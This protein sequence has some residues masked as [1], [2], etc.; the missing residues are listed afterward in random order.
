MTLTPTRRSRVEA[1][2]LVLALSGAALAGCLPSGTS[3]TGSATPSASEAPTTAEPTT[4]PDPTT[5]APTAVGTAIPGT[6]T[7]LTSADGVCT[8]SPRLI[9]ESFV[10]EG[11]TLCSPTGPTTAPPAVPA[12][13]STLTVPVGDRATAAVRFPPGGGL[14]VATNAGPCLWDV[15]GAT[16]AWDCRTAA[17][18]FPYLD[19]SGLANIGIDAIYVLPASIAHVPDLFTTPGTEWSIPAIV[20]GADAMPTR[21]AP[22]ETPTAEVWAGTNGHGVVVMDVAG[23][24]TSR[25]TTAAGLPSD[26]VRDLAAGSNH[27]K[28]GFGYPVWAATSGGVASWDGS[29][30]TSYTTVDGLP[31]NDVRGI[32]VAYD[33]VVWVATAGGPASFDGTAWHAYTAADGVPAMDVMDVATTAWGMWFATAADGLL[34]FIPS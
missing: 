30:W 4:T 28:Y 11:T 10:A 27:A 33:G 7:Q 16:P 14:V 22:I 31:S 19:I 9:G 3:P 8:D 5:P 13:W 12:A 20:G 6:W 25:Q 17:D 23:G 26:D 21:I 29:A 34:V 24:T 2:A 1:L 32:A 15:N 18:G